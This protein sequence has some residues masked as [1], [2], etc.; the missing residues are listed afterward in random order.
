MRDYFL[1]LSGDFQFPA[2]A[3]RRSA[4]Y[5]PGLSVKFHCMKKRARKTT[6]RRPAAARPRGAPTVVAP[7]AVRPAAP[8]KAAYF[9]RELSWLAFNRRV[10]E[11][12]QN[13]RHP[14]L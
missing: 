1:T 14:L 9:N 3:S 8:G 12:A 6:S 7:L 5:G 13:S 10:L 4:Q 11:Q 2:F